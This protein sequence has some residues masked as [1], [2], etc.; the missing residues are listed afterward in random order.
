MAANGYTVAVVLLSHLFW[1]AI[2]TKRFTKL[3]EPYYQKYG[4][5]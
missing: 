2:I 4:I 3:T 5:K 1:S